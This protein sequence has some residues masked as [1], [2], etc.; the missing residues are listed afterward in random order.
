MP[1][2]Y[3]G[4]FH[5]PPVLAPDQTGFDDGDPDRPFAKQALSQK[6]GRAQFVPGL[7]TTIAG[8]NG[9]FP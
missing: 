6:L 4:V 7:S 5:R 8:F 3:A 1:V 2:P 9:I